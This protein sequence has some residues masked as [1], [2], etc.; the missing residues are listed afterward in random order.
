[1]SSIRLSEQHGVNPS[2]QQ[3]YVC[4][5]DVG[6]ILFGRLKGDQEAPRK[7]CIDKEPC[8]ECK[9]WM[10]QGVIL[11]STRVGEEGDN[12]YRT[13][14]WVVLKEDAVRRM[15]VDEALIEHM[16]KMRIAFIEDQVWDM[17]GLPRS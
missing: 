16:L 13:G 4:M 7:V 6:V 3:C 17:L 15:P 14:G 10:E 8:D 11:I 1:M 2:L 5:K 9:K 12:P